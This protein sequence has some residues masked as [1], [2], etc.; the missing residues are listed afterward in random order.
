MKFQNNSFSVDPIGVKTVEKS[1][2]TE[3]APV[4]NPEGHELSSVDL[5]RK[6][7]VRS[8]RPVVVV[9]DG[10]GGGEATLGN[11]GG[12]GTGSGSGQHVGC[13]CVGK[14]SKK[15]HRCE[16]EKKE[17]GREKGKKRCVV[18]WLSMRS[19][20]PYRKKFYGGGVTLG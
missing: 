8:L 19:P 13:G 6:V 17:K 20:C 18:G 9:S 11:E 16:V 12:G 1:K 15:D 3:E 4:E 5:E 7:G 2:H 14:W 10:S